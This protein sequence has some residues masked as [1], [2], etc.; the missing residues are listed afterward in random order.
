MVEK[1]LIKQIFSVLFDLILFIH[2]WK[3]R[4]YT[5]YKKEVKKKIVCF[6][7]FDNMFSTCFNEKGENTEKKSY[8]CGTQTMNFFLYLCPP[9]KKSILKK[10]KQKTRQ[11]IEQLIRDFLLQKLRLYPPNI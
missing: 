7:V 1:I 4:N 9:E 6:L 2:A 8:F 11:N 10:K 3:K 5:Y